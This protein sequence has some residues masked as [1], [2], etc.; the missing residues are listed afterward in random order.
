MTSL[1]LSAITVGKNGVS[2]AS[3][4]NWYKKSLPGKLE[5][6]LFM[7]RVLFIEPTQVGRGHLSVQ[8][9]DVDLVGR[10]RIRKHG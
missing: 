5:R 6:A 10:K 3:C 9:I 1:P 4:L 2:R 8:D 7:G